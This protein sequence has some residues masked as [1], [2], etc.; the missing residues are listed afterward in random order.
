VVRSGTLSAGRPRSAARL[1]G[2]G[3]V[4]ALAA[5]STAAAAGP[6]NGYRGQAARIQ[7]RADKLDSLTHRALLDLYALDASL[8]RARQRVSA[9]GDRA[10]RLSA[11]SR[12]LAAELAS[13]RHTLSRA[14]LLLGAQLRARYEQGDVDPVAVVLG[15]ASLSRA[16][17]RLDDLSRVANQSKEIAAVATGAQTRLI[18]VVSALAAQRRAAA[19]ALASA[20]H[21]EGALASVR[22]SRLAYVDSLQSQRR[23]AQ[24]QVRTLLA[25]ASAVEAK[26]QQL[27]ASS[28]AAA[29][30]ASAGGT[31]ATSPTTTTT[32]ASVPPPTHG[33]TLTVSATGYSLP[34]HTASGLPVGWGVVAVD[35]SVIPLGTKMTVPGYGEAVAADVGSAVHGDMIDLW[36]PTLAQA[37]AWGR[38]T[39]TITLH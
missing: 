5:G 38:R 8:A 9:L 19:T 30:S 39:V 22:A 13:A 20:G 1:A 34:G 31:T 14:R 33:R 11:R 10:A 26:S 16:V 24:A 3:I 32:Q 21:A 36:F 17:T 12:V 15:S 37:R 28:G 35:P 23:L 27:Q 6:G 18:T 2:I 29:Q 7:V 25:E 4:L